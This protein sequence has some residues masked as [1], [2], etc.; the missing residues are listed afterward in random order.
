M[1]TEATLVFDDSCPMCKVYTGAFQSLGWSERAPFSSAIEEL[2]DHLDLDR[3]RHEIP[4]VTRSAETGEV[5]VHYGLDGLSRLLA[6]KMPWLAWWFRHPA[7]LTY[8]RPV[9]EFISYNRREMAGAPPPSQ[10][11]DC[12]P[13]HH[14]TWMHR[15]QAAAL[16]ATVVLAVGSVPTATASA[17]V[18]G[19]ATERLGAI[20][21]DRSDED[22]RTRRSHAVTSA[23]IAAAAARL[24]G[25]LLP[26]PV[27]GAVGVVA[28]IHQIHRRRKALA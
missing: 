16:G 1:N 22:R 7:V 2:G 11:F 26:T 4:M 20:D 9:Y 12:A 27:A 17:V 5:T 19:V 28:G 14:P 24:V 18:G 6:A 3:A 15:Y 13:D 25:R 23:F 10:G 8:G 21:S